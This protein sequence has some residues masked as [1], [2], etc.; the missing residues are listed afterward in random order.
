MS[1]YELKNGWSAW[2]KLLCKIGLHQWCYVRFAYASWRECNRCGR[3]A[4]D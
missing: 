3:R 2:D 4:N 1:N